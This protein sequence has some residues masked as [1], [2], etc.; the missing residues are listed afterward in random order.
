MSTTRAAPTETTAAESAD[1]VSK[2][3]TVTDSQ[4]SHQYHL[5]A[6]KQGQASSLIRPL[7]SPFGWIP[8]LATTVNF[9]FIFGASNS[10][11]VF[12]TYYLN[13]RFPETSAATLSWIGSLI[14]TSMFCLNIFTGALADKKGY[15]FS[16]FIGTG[17]CTLAYALASFSTKVWQL[18]LTQGVLFGIGASFLLAPTNSLAA[19]WFDKHRG[20]AT[21]ISLAGSSIGGLW[22]TV[23]TQA[24][25]DRMGSEWALR[26]LGILTFF[27]TGT[28]N[29][30]YFQRVPPKP[31]KR[32][33]EY[34]VA[35]R[36]TFWLIALELFAAYTG[37]WALVFYIGTTAKQIGGTLQDGSNLLVVLN[38][39]N[40]VGRILTGFIA[41]RIGAIDTLV[42]SLVL[43]VAVEMPLWMTAKSMVPLYVLCTLYG[44][45]GSTFISLNPVIVAIYFKDDP[46]SSIMGMTNM[47][48]GLGGLA[49]SLSQGAIFDK[50]DRRSKFTNTII[51]SS[52]FILFAAI[53]SLVLRVHIKKKE[54]GI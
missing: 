10:Y 17:I 49:G 18:M 37:Y 13:V 16:A 53:V 46:L 29:L 27:V 2:E 24:I 22:F 9:M 1:I 35:R 11:G 52:M 4:R 20:L 39:S 5:P 42:L 33:V 14:T 19:S 30:L 36:L 51:F 43:T 31:R 25:M 32:I 47:F 50:Y 28:M 15:R 40:V 3:K 12:S 8:T 23:L 48:S 38:A 26:I 54:K 41:D 44:L 45:I 7:D 6:D 21:G 34:Q